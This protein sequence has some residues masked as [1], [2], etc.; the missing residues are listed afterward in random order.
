MLTSEREPIGP[1]IERAAA[2]VCTVAGA[3][4]GIAVAV[5]AV[6]EAKEAHDAK[7]AAEAEKEQPRIVQS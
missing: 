5:K 3:V 6:I 1:K 2:I 4:G 7:K